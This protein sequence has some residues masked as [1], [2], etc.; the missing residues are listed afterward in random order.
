MTVNWHEQW[1]LFAQNFHNGKAHISLA[2]YNSPRT[3]RLLPGPGFGDLSHPTTNLMLELMHP[4]IANQ[5]V[6]DIGSG[7]GILSLAALLLGA[8]SA[9]GIDIDPE[10]ISHAQANAQLNNLP[11]TYSLTPPANLSPSILLL[12]MIL[13]EQIQVHP[14]AFNSHARLWITSGILAIQTK[15]YLQQAHQWGWTL[16]EARQKGEWMGFIMKIQK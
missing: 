10:A 9:H 5:P 6:L 12:N 11:A 15:A 3:L 1:A 4:H 2:P 7:S 8:R 13:P 16:V 14:P